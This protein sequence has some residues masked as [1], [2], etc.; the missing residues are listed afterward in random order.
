[1]MKT[2]SLSLLFYQFSLENSHTFFRVFFFFFGLLHFFLLIIIQI[3][4]PDAKMLFSSASKGT[5]TTRKY[6][7][8]KTQLRYIP[9]EHVTQLEI[10]QIRECFWIKESWAI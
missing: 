6:L 1:M 10:V 9:T 8:N 2:A 5:G 7:E 3:L 4:S